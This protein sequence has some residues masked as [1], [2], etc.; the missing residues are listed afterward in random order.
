MQSASTFDIAK[1]PFFSRM[2]ATTAYI[3]SN[4][5]TIITK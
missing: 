2:Q 4:K 5:T 3:F 1:A